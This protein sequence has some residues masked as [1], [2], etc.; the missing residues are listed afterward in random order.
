MVLDL[1]KPRGPLVRE[2]SGT[3]LLVVLTT[4]S[5]AVCVLE[6]LGEINPDAPFKPRI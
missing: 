2:Q 1:F 5:F 4:T 3:W 6:E